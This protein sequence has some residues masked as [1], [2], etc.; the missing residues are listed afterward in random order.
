MMA[1]PTT[2][3]VSVCPTLQKIPVQAARLILFC[4]LTMVVTAITWSG[5][6]ACRMPRKNPM[7]M[8]ERKLIIYRCTSQITY[9]LKKWE[10]K[11]AAARMRSRKKYAAEGACAPQDQ[12]PARVPVPQKPGTINMQLEVK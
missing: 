9:I 8:M 10:T 12:S 6:V 4:R 11:N 1:V 5:S 7:A 3:I 2:K